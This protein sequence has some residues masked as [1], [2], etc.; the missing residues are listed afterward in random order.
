ME[1]NSFQ[2]YKVVENSFFKKN[3]IFDMPCCFL[4][5]DGVLIKDKHYIKKKEDVELESGVKDFLEN[6]KVN[7][8][9]AVIVTNQSGISRGITSWE[10]YDEVTNRMLELIGSNSPIIG[11]FANSYIRCSKKNWRKPNPFMINY[12]SKLFGITKSKSIMIGDRCSDLLAGSR[13][14]LGTLIHL[15]TGHGKKERKQVKSYNDMDKFIF[16]ENFPKLYFLKKLSEIPI[17]IL[18]INN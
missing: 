11:I 12:A 17:K 3:E 7:R 15:E 10:D 6:L 9:P 13:A 16:N 14:N 8:I 2:K 1:S 18:K 4:D 5:R